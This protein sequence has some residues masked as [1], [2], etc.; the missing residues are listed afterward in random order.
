MQV[1][2]NVT[3]PSDVTTALPQYGKRS[4]LIRLENKNSPHRQP[5]RLRRIKDSHSVAVPQGKHKYIS[6]ESLSIP[7]NTSVV[8]SRK[9][10]A[11]TMTRINEARATKAARKAAAG[12]VPQAPRQRRRSPGRHRGLPPGR[13]DRNRSDCRDRNTR[14]TLGVFPIRKRLTISGPTQP[15]QLLPLRG[16]EHPPHRPAAQTRRI[17]ETDVS[18]AS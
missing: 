8:Q 3:A 2:R 12:P 17:S 18:A 6:R 11:R 5:L 10:S 15:G 16:G 7:G 13:S 9:P 4:A 14:C 1:T